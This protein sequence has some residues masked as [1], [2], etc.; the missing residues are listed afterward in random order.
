MKLFQELNQFAKRRCIP[1]RKKKNET[2]HPQNK[3]PPRFKTQK[4]GFCFAKAS[5][6]TPC[7][8]AAAHRP[9]SQSSSADTD[10]RANHARQCCLPRDV[11]VRDQAGGSGLWPRFAAAGHCT[12]VNTKKMPW[13]RPAIDI[14]CVLLCFPSPRLRV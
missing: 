9:R 2:V 12:S 7:R 3:V 11:Y 6:C 14:G 8:T 13:Q 10:A 5:S 4:S 1:R